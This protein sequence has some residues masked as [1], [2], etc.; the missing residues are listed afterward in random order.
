MSL[1]LVFAIPPHL[2]AELSTPLKLI[3]GIPLPGLKEGDFDH[4]TIDLE[5]RRLYL[6]AEA[7][8][9]VQVFDTQT[10]KLVHTIRGIEAPHSIVYRGALKRLDA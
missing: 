5:G 3:A 9:L 2:K 7:N 1:L 6:T 4:F 10:N 8:R